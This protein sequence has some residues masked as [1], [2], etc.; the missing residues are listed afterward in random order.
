MSAISGIHHI[1]AISGP[2]QETVDTYAGVLGLRLVKTT[3]NFDDP[4]TYHLYFGD[5]TGR[6]GTIL[7]F[8]PW[9][10][11][12][13]GRQGASMVSATSFLVPLGSLDAWQRRLET[14]G[15]HVTERTH[16]FD[17]EVLTAKAPD[18]L[19]IEIVATAEARA[20]DADVWTSAGVPS[21]HAIRGFSGATLPA[22]DAPATEK[23]LTDVFGWEREATSDERIR[24]RAPSQNQ[25][26]PGSVIDLQMNPA[27]AAGRLGQGTVHHIALRARD[28]EEQVHWQE[29]LRD[30]DI[31]VT[32]VKDRQYFRSIYFRHRRW[33]SGVLF[34]IATDAP[35]FLH[36][37]PEASLGT[38]LKLPP[39]L[40]S[41]RDEIEHALPELRRPAATA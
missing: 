8:F 39:W 41:R 16:R 18:G 29:R 5:R 6:P 21:E 36:D 12:V 11:A 37:E 17:T 33:T 20:V 27:N 7:T 15:L 31:R 24:L 30:M 38:T 19:P 26:V 35:G 14:A 3:V 40:E 34:E 25:A 32:E 2:A 22:I 28:D 9:A 13:P 1:T 10:S 4:G 23:L